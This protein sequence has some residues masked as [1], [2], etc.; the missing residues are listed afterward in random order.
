MGRPPAHTSGRGTRADPQ[1]LKGKVVAA[2]ARGLLCRSGC[3][4]AIGSQQVDVGPILALDF[5]SFI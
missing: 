4:Y 1:R 2:V 5:M 3:R